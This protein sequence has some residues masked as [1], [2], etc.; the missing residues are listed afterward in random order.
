MALTRRITVLLLAVLGLAGLVG[1]ELWL[2]GY[3]EKSHEERAAYGQIRHELL[4]LE[5]LV[6]DVDLAFRGYVLVRQPQFL[7]PMAA[8]EGA[9]TETLDRLGTL[10]AQQTEFRGRMRILAPRVKEF[11]SLKRNLTKRLDEGMDEGVLQY[12]RS[13]EGLALAAT[14]ALAFQDFDRKIEERERIREAERRD[15]RLRIRT[16][17]VATTLGAL[18]IGISLGRSRL[19]PT[20]RVKE[21]LAA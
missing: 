14:L 2:L 6:A 15:R 11:V 20:R 9:I 8:A 16:G 4:R 13:G 1:G 3:A 10:T 12:I 19:Q 5:R 18:G 21:S 7:E 17:F